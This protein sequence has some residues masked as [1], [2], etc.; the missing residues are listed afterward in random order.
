MAPLPW[1]GWMWVQL[2]GGGWVRYWSAVTLIALGLVFAIW[3]RHALGGNWS[4]SVTVKEGHELVQDGP[5]RWVRHPIYTGV[6]VMILGT[7]LAA[8]RVHGLLAFPIALAALW[9]KSRMEERWMAA[10]FADRYATYRSRTWALIPFV[11]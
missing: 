11:L 1:S 8:G 6:L 4:G 2:I 10:Q 3:A 5:Y 7:G 9:L